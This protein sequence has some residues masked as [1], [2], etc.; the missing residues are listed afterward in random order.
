MS[1]R[2]KRRVLICLG[3][4]LLC[5]LLLLLPACGGGREKKEETVPEE[6]SAAVFHGSGLALHGD[7]I[8]DVKPYY[9]P[10]TE[11]LSV[12]VRLE[13]GAEAR[14]SRAV[15]RLSGED[16]PVEERVDPLPLPAE[17]VVQSGILTADGY[18]LLTA[19][20]T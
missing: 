2:K 5:A 17:E 4:C 19:S 1:N 20:G 11:T 14:Y 12:A 9:D 10:E 3:S 6:V 8:A 7:P 13:D 18:V 15:F 16:D